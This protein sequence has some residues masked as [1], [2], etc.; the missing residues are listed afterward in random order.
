[1]M[2][3]GTQEKSLEEQFRDGL[4]KDGAVLLAERVAAT[5]AELATKG[6]EIVDLR[7]QLEAANARADA[8]EK[9][10]K[11]APKSVSKKPASP[12]PR[13]F[14]EIK[15]DDALEPEQLRDAIGDAEDVEIVLVDG[16]GR[17]VPGSMPIN[18][19]GNVWNLRLQGLMLTEPVEITAPHEGAGYQVA[20][21]ALLLDG[22]LAA[23]RMRS[24]P[25]NVAAGQRV[26][27]TDDIV[28]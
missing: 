10:S 26:K 25:V 7:S 1:M 8:A 19:T 27:L 18:V 13:K 6:E 9:V 20:G 11:E 16:N 5:E 23:R 3:E 21:Y 22:K 28:F 4:D 15:A 24:D 14:P 2:T 17:E 12:K